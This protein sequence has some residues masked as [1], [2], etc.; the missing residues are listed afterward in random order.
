MVT[1]LENYKTAKPA[2]VTDLTTCTE[3]N[4]VSTCCT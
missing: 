2:I 4:S 1:A 3:F